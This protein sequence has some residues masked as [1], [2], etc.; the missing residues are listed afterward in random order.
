MINLDAHFPSY[1]QFNPEVPV[2]CVTPHEGRVIHR[3]F[4]TSP[5]SPSGRY[6]ALFRMPFENRYPVPGERGQIVWVDLQEGT[7]AVIAD[8]C[9]WESQ[10]GANVQWGT[11]DTEIYYNDVDT[12]TWKPIGVRLNPF[13]GSKHIFEQG[14]FVISPD[15]KS[16][17]TTCPLRARRTQDGYGVIVPDDC[18][19]K[20]NGLPYDDGIYI[21][22]I[23]SGQRKQLISLGS[24]LES[25]GS[26][27]NLDTY[28]TGESYGFQCRYNPQGTRLMMIL[29]WLKPGGGEIKQAITVKSDGSDVRLAVSPEQ[30]SKGGHHINWHP[31]GE[32]LTMNLNINGDGIR[33]VQFRYDGTGLHKL[34]DNPGSGHPTVHS[35]GT[36]LLTD[37]YLK[38][39]PAYGDGTV[40]LRWVDLR[41]GHETAIVRIHTQQAYDNTLRVDPHP[42]WDAGFKRIAF[43]GFA[44]GTRRVYVADVSSLL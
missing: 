38:D 7:E 23:E 11:S 33:F 36:H 22:D 13:T 19:P 18:L 30:Y 17:A 16:A 2:W 21:T 10:I 4:D 25:L 31:D 29:R 20:N 27:V 34:V 15:G 1:T 44:D 9:G 40:P 28:R 42:A 12:T 35:N 14:L 8:T 26:Q 37:A 39:T 32:H 41:N 5:F 24:M 43:N 6:M 3:F